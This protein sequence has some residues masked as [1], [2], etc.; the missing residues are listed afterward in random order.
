MNGTKLIYKLL[1][2]LL[3]LLAAATTEVFLVL[4]LRYLA[5]DWPDWLFL[6]VAIGGSALNAALLAAAYAFYL[7]E[8]Q[9]L[10][11]LCI[12]AYALLITF[13]AILY[14]LL[15]TG[16]F[17]I[18][19]DE[20]ALEAY[21]K[22]SG[23]WMG[24]LFT[25]LQFLQ[26]VILPIP[27]TVTVV[28]GTAVFGPLTGSLL[29]LLGIL[30]GSL[31]AFFVGR[32][33]GT[34]VVG[35]LIGK[36]TL[37]TWLKKIKGKDKLLLT[38]MFLLPVFPDDVLCFVAGISSMSLGYFFTVILISRIL[39]IFA[40]S[41]SI[42]LI[43]FDTWWG[44]L[45][46]GILLVAVIVLFVFLYRKSDAILGWF[47]RK[48]H[49][50]TRVKEQKTKDEFLLEVVGPDGSIVSKGV[51]REGTDSPPAEKQKGE[52]E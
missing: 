19:R 4:S 25:T 24:F 6:L 44:L 12:T 36:E 46:W 35:W 40:T 15:R 9:S 31:V 45:I 43:P 29:S 34:R 21:L 50:E 37:E 48:F 10:L 27:S 8:K 51:K 42:T 30:I 13:G 16:F 20:E 47:E 26:V 5:A 3:L 32:Y 38:A 11:K 41:Y 1:H 28:A 52:N 23:G 2:I 14:A 22:E 17:E 18:M 39:A 7:L 33:A 49:R